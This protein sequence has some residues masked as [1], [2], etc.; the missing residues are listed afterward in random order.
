[1]PLNIDLNTPYIDHEM[2]ECNIAPSI[3][4]NDPS[5]SNFNLSFKDLH[6]SSSNEEYM[7]EANM[8]NCENDFE[9]GIFNINEDIDVDA[10]DSNE[11]HVME[12]E[13]EFIPNEEDGEVTEFNQYESDGE[14]E[15]IAARTLLSS[16][17]KSKDGNS[18]AK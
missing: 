9:H 17:P 12:E 11:V 14:T 16:I 4:L 13:S 5:S 3:N 6:G 7:E 2:M 18:L 1:M 15:S 10:L 8:F